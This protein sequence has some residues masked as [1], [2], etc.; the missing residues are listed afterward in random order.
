MNI[1]SQLPQ[2]RN[3]V[4]KNEPCIVLNDTQYSKH[5][6]LGEKIHACLNTKK[7]RSNPEMIEKFYFWL[8]PVTYRD[9]LGKRKESHKH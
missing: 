3:A 1:S 5:Q 9:W 2:Q 8:L 4:K 7:T 6:T